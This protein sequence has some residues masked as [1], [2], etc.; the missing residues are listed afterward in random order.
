MYRMGFER[1]QRKKWI[2]VVAGRGVAEAFRRNIGK[3]RC[4]LGLGEED[5]E[6]I[7]LDRLGTR[8]WRPKF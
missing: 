1:G 4:P 2:G 6:D 7:L 5:V 3:G 8:N